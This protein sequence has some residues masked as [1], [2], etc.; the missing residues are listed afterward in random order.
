MANKP[1]DTTSPSVSQGKTIQR[2]SGGCTESVGS[3]GARVGNQQ[4]LQMHNG[5][6]EAASF[7]IQK[8]CWDQQGYEFVW[9]CHPG[10]REHGWEWGEAAPGQRSH[11]VTRATLLTAAR[12]ETFQS[13][14]RIKKEGIVLTLSQ[15]VPVASAVMSTQKI[16]DIKK[17]RETEL[18]QS[19]CGYGGWNSRCR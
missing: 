15:S 10:P 16:R 1:E 8:Q 3:P 5:T 7:G 12:V 4:C 11:A 2:V 9:F 6:M 14:D 17:V 18:R 19:S 13:K